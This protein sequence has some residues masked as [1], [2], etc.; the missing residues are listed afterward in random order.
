M[1]LTLGRYIQL[2]KWSVVEMMGCSWCG[3]LTSQVSSSEGTQQGWALFRV[4]VTCVS[5]FKARFI[6][7]CSICMGVLPSYVPVNHVRELPV[8][9][10]DAV[11]FARTKL[12][13]VVS[14]HEA[15]GI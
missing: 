1:G 9:P 5:P 4:I 8:S 15:V 3:D 7:F 2:K 6:Y 13:T 12:Q 14:C 10:E 11:V